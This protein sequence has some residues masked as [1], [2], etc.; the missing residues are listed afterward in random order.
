[1]GK[2]EV[3]PEQRWGADA[4]LHSALESIGPED[5]VLVLGIITLEDGSTQRVMRSA[6]MT[7][8]E[9]LFEMERRKLEILTDTEEQQ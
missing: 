1:M 6:N 9:A 3:L 2:I 4:A 8:A 5:K 7:Q